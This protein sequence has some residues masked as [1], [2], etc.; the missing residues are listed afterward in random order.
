MPA[1][2]RDTKRTLL[3]SLNDELPE[4]TPEYIEGYDAGL[5]QAIRTINHLTYDEVIR[6][7]F[8]DEEDDEPVMMTNLAAEELHDSE[9][10]IFA[11][12]AEQV[13]QM[14]QEMSAEDA[15]EGLGQLGPMV[16][17]PSDIEQLTAHIVRLVAETRVTNLIAIAKLELP[18]PDGKILRFNLRLQQQIMQEIARVIGGSDEDLV[19]VDAWR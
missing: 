13:A 3:D 6:H 1:F 4:G 15:P 16:Q 10:D 14:W 2:L 12:Q 7:D 19:V 11:H 5:A 18:R 17:G 8:E 9:E